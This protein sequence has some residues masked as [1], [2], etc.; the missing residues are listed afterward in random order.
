MQ[1]ADPACPSGQSLSLLF[2][3]F[4]QNES[5]EEPKDGDKAGRIFTLLIDSYIRM[6]IFGKMTGATESSETRAAGWI[7]MDVFQGL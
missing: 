1:F 7:A 3:Q 4:G 5:G 2:L 6:K